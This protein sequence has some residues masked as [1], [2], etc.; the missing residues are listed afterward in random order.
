MG[1]RQPY[2]TPA[3][4]EGGALLCRFPALVGFGRRAH[5]REGKGTLCQYIGK[6]RLFRFLQ[7]RHTF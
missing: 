1:R 2:A 5:P 6:A 3:W 4:G 7:L